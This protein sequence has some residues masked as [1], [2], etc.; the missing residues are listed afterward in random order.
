MKGFN[1]SK[2]ISKETR[3]KMSRAA[4]RTLNGY[5][6][7]HK[8][9]LGMR[10]TDEAK[11]KMSI[12]ATLSGQ[13][14]YQPKGYKHSLETLK[15]MSDIR[16]ANP[17]RYWKGKDRSG[18]FT[19]ES[20]KKQSIRMKERV[21]LGIHNFWKGGKTLENKLARTQLPYKLWREAVFK[22]DDY[23]CQECKKRGGKLNA[24]HVKPFSLFPELRYVIDNGLTLCI[25]CHKKT[26]NY[27]RRALKK[28]V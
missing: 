10:H 15:K 3:L 19:P 26:D 21:R 11:I 9:N 2:P 13:R 28:I 1:G 4:K 25:S 17:N 12:K 23:T 5:K 20:R 14:P 8:T 6:K 22:R 16:K 24:H 7:G 18:M 27:G